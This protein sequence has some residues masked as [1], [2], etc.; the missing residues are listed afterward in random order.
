MEENEALDLLE[1]FMERNPTLTTLTPIHN[2]FKQEH[3]DTGYTVSSLLIKL[4]HIRGSVIE[5]KTRNVTNYRLLKKGY[6]KS[7]KTIV[8]QNTVNAQN[9]IMG[10]SG[11]IGK[12]H[13]SSSENIQLAKSQPKQQKITTL[14]KIIITAIIG[15]I[16]AIISGFIIFKMG[17]N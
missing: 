6:M 12:V 11:N 17:W 16:G 1:S 2:K 5:D 10:N 4:S 7:N 13:Q 9:V 14:K 15:I 3:G 8:N